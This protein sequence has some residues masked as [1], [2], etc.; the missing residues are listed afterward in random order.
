MRRGDSRNRKLSS[1]GTATQKGAAMQGCMARMAVLL[2]RGAWV[3]GT[4]PIRLRRLI[5]CGIIGAA[6]ALAVGESGCSRTYYRHDADEQAKLLISQKQCD[7]RWSL[8]QQSVYGDPHSRYYDPNDPD[9]APVPPDDPTSHEL[10][11]CVYGMKG[12]KRWHQYGDLTELENPGWRDY[13]GE[14]M[15]K[16]DDG[17]YLMDLNDAVRLSL[18]NSRNYQNNVENLYLSALDV[19][20]E[21]YRFDT[22]FFLGTRSTWLHTGSE[23]TPNSSSTLTTVNSAR[24]A[25]LFPAGGQFLV[26]FANT[27]VWQFAGSD[28]NTRA[29]S[30]LSFTFL[31]PFLRAGGREVAMEQLTLAERGL[32]ANVRQMERYRQGFLVDVVMGVGA[33]QGPSRQ[34]GFAGGAGLSGFTGTGTGGFAGVGEASNFGRIGNAGGTGGGAGGAGGAGF[35]GGVAGNVGGFIGLAQQQ[36]QI[37][38]REANLSLQLENLAR[39]EELFAAGRIGS[40]QV[41]Q[42]RQ[43]VQTTRSQYL[44]ALDDYARN[45]ETYFM[46]I[47]GLP[48]DVPIKIDE[49][50]VAQFQFTLPQLSALRT[51]VNVLSERIRSTDD[52]TFEDLRNAINLAQSLDRPVQE[53]F[54]SVRADFK[55]LDQVEG[56]RL[57][58]LTVEKDRKEFLDQVQQ[59]REQF[60]SLER[61]Y[62]VIQDEL[63]NAREQLRPEQRKAVHQALVVQLEA[64]ADLLLELNFNQAG[65]RLEAIVLPSVQ[66]DSEKAFQIARVNRLDLMNQRAEVVDQWRLITFNANR[67]ESDLNVELDGS[68]GTLD[69]N[70]VK[71]RDQR[72]SFSASVRFDS[73]ISRLGERN[74]YRQSLIDYQRVRRSYILFEDSV[75]QGLR[76]TLRRVNLFQEEIELRRMAMRI[77]IRQMDFNQAR[78]KEPPRVGAAGGAQGDPVRDLLGSFD[79]FLQTQNGVMNTYLSYQQLR[80]VL[81]RDLGI[82][83]FDDQGMWIDE[84]LEAAIERSQGMDVTVPPVCPLLVTTTPTLGKIQDIRDDNPEI[85]LTEGIDQ[86]SRQSAPGRKSVALGSELVPLPKPSP[87]SGRRSGNDASK[88]TN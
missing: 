41:D 30:L 66:L 65:V 34:G 57:N 43:N 63:K 32:L 40:F 1:P 36:Q 60:A 23:L 37:R 71:F 12:Y 56:A 81:Y 52:S 11:H 22:Q 21:R 86:P 64:L 61:Q 28:S 55:K 4:C 68:I 83:R 5:S 51:Q 62:A 6:A 58:S 73:P 9:H 7:P 2:R 14:I 44:A 76:A 16:T 77:A 38:N 50:A 25:K 87:K 26:D 49:D 33:L 17:L 24:A 48:P 79:D 78:L 15:E 53:R 27:F 18:L 69:R 82:I 59:L 88:G 70:I 45:L 74:Q 20:F 46:A 3:A 13:L 54:E 47:L 8:P 31:Q 80:M 42:F 10:M 19:A 75:N 84:P 67:L 29:D 35:A 39:M 72:G 85:V